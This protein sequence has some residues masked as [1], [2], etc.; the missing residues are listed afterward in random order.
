LAALVVFF[1]GYAAMAVSLRIFLG[2]LPDR[3]GPHPMLGI[4]MSCYAGGLVV[5]ALANSPLQIL[6]AGLLCGAGHGYT[7]PVLFSLVVA[8]AHP[9]ERGAA[10]AFFTALDWIG[11]LLAGPVVGYFI[12]RAGYRRSFMGLALLLVAGVVGFYGFDR[13]R[14]N[15]LRKFSVR[16]E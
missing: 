13:G 10:T 2:W 14:P 6:T 1:G 15:D 8:R 4:A 11:L 3:L 12:E 5:L 9:R 7:F 16:S